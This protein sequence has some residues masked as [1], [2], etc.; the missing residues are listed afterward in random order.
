M[1]LGRAVAGDGVGAE[2]QRRVG[3]HRGDAPPHLGQ[4]DAQIEKSAAAA[5]DRLGQ[6]DAQKVSV[7]KRLPQRRIVAGAG[8]FEFGEA[9]GGGACRS[10]NSRAIFPTAS[11]SS[12]NVKSIGCVSSSGRGRSGF[13]GHAE[14]GH[15]DDG[16]LNLVGTA[17]ER[18]EHRGP[19]R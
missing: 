4:Q 5:A 8:G 11:W 19:N 9:V 14:A 16:S 1:L 12:E 7:G 6:G 17:A 3:G 2:H 18:V 15:R 10:N 13:T